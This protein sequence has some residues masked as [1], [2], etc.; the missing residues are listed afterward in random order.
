MVGEAE[1]EELKV[2]LKEVIEEIFEETIEAITVAAIE[3]EAAM[4]PNPNNIKVKNLVT[5]K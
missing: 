5:T 3:V 4:T 1:A 2:N